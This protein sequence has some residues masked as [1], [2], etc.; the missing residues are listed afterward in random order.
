MSFYTRIKGVLGRLSEEYPDFL[1]IAAL[2]A[3][4]VIIARPLGVNSLLAAHG[5]D[6]FI[7]AVAMH[8]AWQDGDLLGRWI[9]SLIH[10][11]GYP[12]FN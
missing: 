12:V 4:A 10:G 2:L 11:Y 6:I 7:K 3:F 8:Q 9:P 1:A 5:E